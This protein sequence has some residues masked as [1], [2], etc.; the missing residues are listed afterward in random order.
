MTWPARRGWRPSRIALR[1]LAFNLLVVF[2]PV[3]GVLYLNV[4]EARLLQAQEQSMVQQ[5]RVLAAALAAEPALDAAGIERLFA[6]LGPRGDARYRVYDLH[7]AMLADSAR[8]RPVVVP[9]DEGASITHHRTARRS[10]PHS[11]SPR[12]LD[13]ELPEE[14]RVDARLRQTPNPRAP[15]TAGR[16]RGGPGRAR[17]PL[18]IGD[19]TD[20]R[21]AVGDDVQRAP[22]RAR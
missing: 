8:G 9:D 5:G 4:Y 6:R 17:R 11:L 2:V 12:G 7:G 13:R 20:A 22:G 14:G 15:E 19:T 3:V 18:R 16:T 10:Q 1:L 21:P